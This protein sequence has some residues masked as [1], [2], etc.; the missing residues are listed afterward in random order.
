[1]QRHVS[2]VEIVLTWSDTALALDCHWGKING[3]QLTGITPLW[4]VGLT[5]GWDRLS[6]IEFGDHKG[7]SN[8]LLEAIDSPLARQANACR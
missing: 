8:M 2:L 6:P 4:L 3:T 7:A 1:M 5:R